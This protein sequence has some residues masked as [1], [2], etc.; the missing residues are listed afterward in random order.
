MTMQPMKLVPLLMPVKCAVVL[1]FR[2]ATVTAL[3]I[4]RMPV[5]CVEAVVRMSMQMASVTMRTTARI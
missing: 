5:E 1:A 2:L 3:V 4:R